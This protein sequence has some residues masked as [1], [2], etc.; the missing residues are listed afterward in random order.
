MA[1]TLTIY[2]IL[3]EKA[4]NYLTET[5]SNPRVRVVDSQL[6]HIQSDKN[7]DKGIQL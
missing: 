6:E 2:L 4:L 3:L 5:E 7:L 1:I